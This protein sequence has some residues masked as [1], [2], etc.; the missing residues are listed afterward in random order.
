M[1]DRRDDADARLATLQAALIE[2]ERASG[3]I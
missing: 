3:S 2:G 1:S